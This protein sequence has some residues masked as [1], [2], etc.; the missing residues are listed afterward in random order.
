MTKKMETKHCGC[1][2]HGLNKYNETLMTVSDLI[3]YVH[4]TEHSDHDIMKAIYHCLSFYH[5]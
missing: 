4:Q 2:T 1:Q 5:G 3:S